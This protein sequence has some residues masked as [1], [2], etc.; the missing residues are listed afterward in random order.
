MLPSKFNPL[1]E[2]DFFDDMWGF[3]AG[4]WIT[5]V[6]TGSRMPISRDNGWFAFTTGALATNEE[7]IDFND[8]LLFTN[9]KRP[10]YSTRIQL[11]SVEDVEVELGLVGAAATDYIRFFYDYSS[12][13]TN[14]RL[15]A[16]DA[17]SATSVTSIVPV[18]TDEVVLSWR[19]NSDTEVEFFIDGVSAGTIG[20]N[21][22][23]ASLQPY[24]AVRT[25]TASSKVLNVDYVRIQQ[26]RI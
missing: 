14:W 15:Q 7:S 17:G 24:V 4:S 26:D 1:V 19:F 18:S 5:R 21:I 11:P 9:T 12:G 10:I 6:S 16:S 22:P 25:E 13:V 2:S 23:T 8:F 3:L 20:V